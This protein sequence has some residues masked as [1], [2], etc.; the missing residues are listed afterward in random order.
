[1]ARRASSLAFFKASLNTLKALVFLNIC[2]EKT[3]FLDL[4]STLESLILLL[5]LMQIPEVLCLSDSPLPEKTKSLLF[6]IEFSLRCLR[7]SSFS[8][9]LIVSVLLP[10]FESGK[11]MRLLCYQGQ[12]LAQA[13]AGSACC[14]RL[15]WASVFQGRVGLHVPCVDMRCTSA[16]EKEDDR[17]RLGGF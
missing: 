12:M 13:D 8:S 16:E 9:V 15:E 4:T 1:M 3:K 11:M 2:E 14:D 7:S 6:L 10:V 5:I 17:F